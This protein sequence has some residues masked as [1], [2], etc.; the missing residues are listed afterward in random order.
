MCTTALL[1]YAPNRSRAPCQ[2]TL[3]ATHR[4]TTDMWSPG[5]HY[6]VNSS[7]LGAFV[8]GDFIYAAGGFP[9]TG[10]VISKTFRYE[11]LTDSWDDAAIAD[12]PAG[13]AAAASGSYHDGW[14]VAGGFVAGSNSDSVIFW[15]PNSNTWLNLPSMLMPQSGGAGSLMKAFMLLVV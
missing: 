1:S 4:T 9:F 10:D 5:T 12:L 15:D 13:R 3:G 2:R 8:H 11:P 7:S 6:P 14:V